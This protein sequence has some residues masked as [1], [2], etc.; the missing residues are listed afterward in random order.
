MLTLRL[1]ACY[2]STSGNALGGR[3]MKRA[4]LTQDEINQ[5][6]ERLPRSASVRRIRL[7]GD[8]IDASD[9]DTRQAIII[10]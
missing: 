3:R 9:D 2:I 6:I 7:H 10:Q 5:A 4:K 1:H 8:G